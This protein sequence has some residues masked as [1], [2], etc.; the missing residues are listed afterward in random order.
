MDQMPVIQQMISI[1]KILASDKKSFPLPVYNTQM[2]SD[3]Q[4]S[5][6]KQNRG[7]WTYCETEEKLTE[8]PNYRKYFDEY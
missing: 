8:A 1:K 3:E 4:M 2:P 5:K 6:K 7:K